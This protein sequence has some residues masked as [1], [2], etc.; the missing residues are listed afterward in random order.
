MRLPEGMQEM[1]D[2]L[3]VVNAELDIHNLRGESLRTKK[4]ALEEAIREVCPHPKEH[5]KQE[6]SHFSGSYYDRACTYDWTVCKLC[7]AKSEVRTTTHSY[8]G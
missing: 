1:L 5:L 4:K 2:K 3:S 6:S 7:G 8:Y